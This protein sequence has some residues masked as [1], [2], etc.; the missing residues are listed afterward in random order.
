M[1]IAVSLPRVL[2]FFALIIL[3]AGVT[4]FFYNYYTRFRKGRWQ[5]RKH[6][7][8]VCFLSFMLSF[9]TALAGGIIEYPSYFRLWAWCGLIGIILIYLEYVF[10]YRNFYGRFPEELTGRKKDDWE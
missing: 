3:A 9:V 4:Y 8:K 7:F 10:E 6:G 1:L 2:Q 5:K